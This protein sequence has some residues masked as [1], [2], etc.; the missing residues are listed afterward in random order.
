MC[1]AGGHGAQFCLPELTPE[2]SQANPEQ[3]WL[4]AE[5][6]FRELGKEEAGE[7]KR[8]IMRLT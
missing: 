6:S 8:G 1:A 3:E 2:R 7:G 5:S 4:L